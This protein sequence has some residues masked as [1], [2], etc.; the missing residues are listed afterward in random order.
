MFSR[1]LLQQ[2][3]ELGTGRPLPKT[4]HSMTAYFGAG[5]TSPVKTGVRCYDFGNIIPMKMYSQDWPQIDILR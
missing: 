5:A 1:L 4:V 2:I 3:H